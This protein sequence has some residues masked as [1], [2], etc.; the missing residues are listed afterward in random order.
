MGQY[1]TLSDLIDSYEG[2]IPEDQHARWE[3]RI[4]QAER[5]IQAQARSAGTTI[6]SLITRERTTAADVRDVVCAMVARVLRNPT[7]VATQAAGPFSVT[8]APTVASGNLWL[9][10]EDRQQLGLRRR[11]GGSVELVDDALRRPLRR[12]S[13]R[14]WRWREGGGHDCD[15]DCAGG[16]C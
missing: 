2:T 14:E 9:T 11:T 6:E 5:L 10:R 1:A 8:A 15:C 7:G 16:C 13:G 3:L 4:N 12:P